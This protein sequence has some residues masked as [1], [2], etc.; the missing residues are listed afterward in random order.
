[1]KKEEAL[2]K[3]FLSQFKTGEDLFSFMKELQKRGIEQFLEAEMD[4]HMG[5][6][7]NAQSSNKNARNGRTTKLIKSSL[8]ETEI[9][10]PRDR[11]ASFDPVVV[12]KRKNMVDGLENIIVSLYARGMS[13]SD[14][15]E[16]ISDLYVIIT[17]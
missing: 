8:G 13:L 17:T 12:P 15:Q 10:V 6:K 14:I 16:Q 2:S 9:S 11:D 4:E 7:K 3:D 1:M 5:Y